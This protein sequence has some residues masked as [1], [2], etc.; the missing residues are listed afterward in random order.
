[1]SRSISI[2]GNDHANVSA[3]L[4]IERSEEYII[5]ILGINSRISGN[6]LYDSI[7][8]VERKI[9]IKRI[10]MKN[11]EILNTTGHNM[12][13]L[14][15]NTLQYTTLHSI[16]YNTLQYTTLLMFTLYFSFPI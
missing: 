9:H 13:D 14:N 5:K 4:N 16:R 3:E 2:L 15:F 11:R 12:P 10:Y 1:M 6:A 8:K 7:L